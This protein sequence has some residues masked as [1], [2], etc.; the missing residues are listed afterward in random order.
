MRQYKKDGQVSQKEHGGKGQKSNEYY[1][2]DMYEPCTSLGGAPD[3]FER[4]YNNDYR[5]K[6]LSSQTSEGGY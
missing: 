3:A 2:R 5:K 6:S 1:K 4:K